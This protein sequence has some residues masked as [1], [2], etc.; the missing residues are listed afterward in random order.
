MMSQNDKNLSALF[1]IK[2]G[3]QPN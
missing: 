2:F 3:T 1:C